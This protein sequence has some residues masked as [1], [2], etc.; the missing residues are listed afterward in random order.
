MATSDSG[1][2]A[3]LTAEVQRLR[4]AYSQA[5]AENRTIK[6]ENCQMKAKISQIEAENS[7]T[8]SENNHIEAELDQLEDFHCPLSLADSL[9]LVYS[10]VGAPMVK[11]RD[12]QAKG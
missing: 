2:I 7:R 11:V 10:H 8:K 1:A 9:H 3:K 6:A 4:T 5:T 12:S